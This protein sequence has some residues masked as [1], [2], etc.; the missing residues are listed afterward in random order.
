MLKH[1][2]VLLEC[3]YLQISAVLADDEVMLTIKPGQVG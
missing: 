1:L 3:V 2:Y